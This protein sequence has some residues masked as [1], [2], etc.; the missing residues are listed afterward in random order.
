MSI[1]IASLINRWTITLKNGCVALLSLLGIG[2]A[3]IGTYN[4][5]TKDSVTLEDISVPPAFEQRGF[6]E[7]VTTRRLLDEIKRLQSESTSA[8]ERVSF[9][10]HQSADKA[11][12]L[13]MAGTGIDVKTIQKFIRDS[14]DIETAKITGDITL[15]QAEGDDVYNVNIRDAQHNRVL[16]DMRYKG[17]PDVVIKQTALK[18]LEVLDPQNAASAYWRRGDEINALRLADV[19]LGNENP[20]DDMYPLNLRIYIN[21]TN[22]KL[23]AAQKDLELLST[24]A[25]NFVPSF[26]AASWYWRERKDYEKSIAMAEKQ[27]ALEPKKFFGYNFKALALAAQDKNE[28]ASI[29]FEKAIALR[30]DGPH[31]YL[32]AAIHFLNNSENERAEKTLR[33]GLAR[34]P[35]N[36]GLKTRYADL[37][38]KQNEIKRGK[39]MYVELL[40]SSPARATLGLAEIALLEKNQQ[41]FLKYQQQLKI[42]FASNPDAHAPPVQRR[43]ESVLTK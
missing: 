3:S 35:E 24:I 10:G 34:F 20:K 43:I 1:Q 5:L 30:P 21:L 31:T 41:D 16:V 28:E 26:G 12:S 8:K 39:Y 9:F 37:L 33:I 23:D 29:Y 38:I 27:I 36:I 2:I 42:A 18:M 22:K 13:Q 15:A 7:T 11:P 4:G 6:S 19:V 25:P 32:T 40:E 17:S 14:L